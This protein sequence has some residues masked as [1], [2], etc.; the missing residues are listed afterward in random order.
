MFFHFKLVLQ[1][2]EVK[3]GEFIYN[4]ILFVIIVNMEKVNKILDS[5]LAMVSTVVKII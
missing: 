2:N 5:T 4:Y 3:C 1:I